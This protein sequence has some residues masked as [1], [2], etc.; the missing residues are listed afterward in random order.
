MTILTVGSNNPAFSF[1]VSKN[2]ATIRDSNTPFKRSVRKGVVYG[3]FTKPDDSEFRLWFKDHEHQSSF[4]DG[5]SDEFE[6]LDRSRYG[7]PYAP[8][9]IITECLG[10]ASKEANEL[11]VSDGTKS[12]YASTTILIANQAYLSRMIVQYAEIADITSEVLIGQTYYSNLTV[13]AYTVHEALNILQTICIMQALA[14]KNTYVPMKED[15]L[16]KFSKVFNRACSPYFPRYLFEVRA[17]QNRDTF[18]K[19]KGDLEGAGMHFA[20]GDTRQQR[21]D[22]IREQL[23]GSKAETLLDIGCGEMFHALRL[24][25]QYETIYAIDADEDMASNNEGKLKGRDIEGVVSIHSRVDLGWIA[26]NQSL[27]ENSDVLM[28]EVLEHIEKDESDQVLFQILASNPNR[29]VVTVP[30]QDFN[31]YY[32]IPDGE[33]RHDDHKWE[34]TFEEFSDSMV[35]FAAE[36]NYQVSVLP[37]GDNVN[38]TSVSILAVFTRK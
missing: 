34:P 18:D 16:L 20:F 14:D 12:A 35:S 31:V 15:G 5:F 21:F 9:A 27:I 30:N 8:I 23:L 2:P 3:W 37:V 36:A 11:D 1:V 33:M 29:V 6:Y 28:T 25:K 7:S 10:S 22:A 32:A 38:D 4:A 13:R 17:I 19:V 24:Q 26:D